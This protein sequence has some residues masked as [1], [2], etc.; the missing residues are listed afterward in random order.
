MA[1]PF[2][3]DGYQEGRWQIYALR[4]VWK[5]DLWAKLI[6]LVDEQ[7]PTRHPQTIRFTFAVDGQDREFYLKVY[8]PPSSGMG[9]IK[10]LLRDSKAVRALK[11]GVA[12]ADRGFGSPIPIAAGEERRLRF[13]RRAFLVTLGSQGVPLPLYLERHRRSLEAGAGLARKREYLKALAVEVRRL[14]QSGFVHGDLIPSNVFVR[15]SGAGEIVFMFMDNDRT[16]HY[17]AWLPHR[18][19]RRNL[20][21]LNRFVL[22]GI[23]LQ[24]RMRFLRY[25][26]WRRVW[27]KDDRRLMKWLEKRTRKRRRECDKVRADVSFRKLMRWDGEFSRHS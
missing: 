15:E 7:L 13:L 2:K 1:I 16:R 22:P 24:D 3:Y 27:T 11:Q 26:L 10:D 19:W 6:H 21:Q 20:V 23:S 17:P 14:H 25:Y 5:H 8:H 12:L 4:E 18:L 9:Q